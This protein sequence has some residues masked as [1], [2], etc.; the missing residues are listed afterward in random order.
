MKYIEY[1][2]LVLYSLLAT[3]AVLMLALPMYVALSLLVLFPLGFFLYRER[4]KSGVVVWLALGSFVLALALGA[5]AYLNGVW[6]E[7]SVTEIRLFGLVPIE[8]LLAAFMHIF[9]FIVLYEYFF[10]DRETESVVKHRSA[11]LVTLLCIFAA[12]LAY[13]Y[14]FSNLLLTNAFAW[15]VAGLL[16]LI[17]FGTI[18]V[19]QDRWSLL[20][21]LSL[22]ALSMLP[23]SWL[24][25]YVALANN[26]RFFANTNEYLYSFTVLGQVVPLEELLFIA[27]LPVA[28]ALFYELFFDD[29]A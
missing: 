21:R 17:G 9:Y 11:F 5:F 4:L 29:E 1:G 10:D 20:R 22:F 27:L 19:Y 23:L 24:Y 14:L 8:A 15:L 7:T 28:V 25:E 13:V 2:S 12:T 3:I 6:F 26:Y 18:L 16:V